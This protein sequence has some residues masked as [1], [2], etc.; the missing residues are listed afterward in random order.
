MKRYE[1]LMIA[2]TLSFLPACG[3]GGDDA[4]GDGD[5]DSSGDGDGDSGDGGDG[6]S[7]DGDGPEAPASCSMLDDYVGEYTVSGAATGEDQRGESTA[8]HMR[9]SIT[10][11]ADYSVDFDTDISF[12]GTDIMTCYDRTTQDFDRR[13]QISYGADDSGEVIN[14]YLD[15][16]HEVVEIQYRHSAESV[17]VRAAID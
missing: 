9:G 17:N 1:L 5:G 15:D 6:D 8:D 3:D 11:E 12:A 16:A 4:T 7:G 2:A 10:I 14:L 13:V